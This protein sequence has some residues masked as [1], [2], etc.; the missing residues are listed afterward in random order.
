MRYRN[1]RS[2]PD[3]VLTN[4]DVDKFQAILDELV[5][6]GMAWRDQFG[7]YRHIDEGH[8]GNA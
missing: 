2:E 1:R 7:V 5:A 6:S 3:P 8:A 4:Q